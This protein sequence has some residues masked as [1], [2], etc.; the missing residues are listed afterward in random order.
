M[1]SSLIAIS[2]VKVVFV[3]IAFGCKRESLLFFLP[4]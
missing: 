2:E 4:E 3:N 1:K